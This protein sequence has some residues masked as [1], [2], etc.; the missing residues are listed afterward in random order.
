VHSDETS[1]WGRPRVL[2]VVFTNKTMTVYRVAKG[3]G[4]DL[5]LEILG[6]AFSGV[7]VS[8]CL[9]IYDDVNPRQ[10]KCYSHHLK[11][12]RLAGEKP[13][14]SGWMSEVAAARCHGLKAPGAG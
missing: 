4:R 8:D 10:Q 5:L 11:A 3:R 13:P 2:V 12:I 14:A 7:L 9:A 1:W 6:P